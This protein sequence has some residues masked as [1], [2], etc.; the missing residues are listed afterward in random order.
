MIGHIRPGP[1]AQ[2]VVHRREE[3]RDVDRVVGRHP[4]QPVAAP[5]DTL[6]NMVNNDSGS[7]TPK[8]APAPWVSYTRAG[9]DVGEVGAANT[10]LENANAVFVRE[11][12]LR[13]IMTE[14]F[15]IILT[16]LPR[17]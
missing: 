17:S 11:M 1:V 16:T 9:C 5:V 10:V 2:C 8:T 4:A 6:P 12:A 15:T 3:V 13:K 7:L 14:D